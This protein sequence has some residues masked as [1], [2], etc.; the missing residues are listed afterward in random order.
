MSVEISIINPINVKIWDEAVLSSENY[1]F[2]HSVAWSKVL[3]N[4]YGYKPYYFVSGNE[5]KFSTLIPLMQIDSILTGRR[6]I[7][8]PFSDFCEPIINGTGNIEEIFNSIKAFAKK[9]GWKYIQFRGGQKLFRNCISSSCFYHHYLH[10]TT[11]EEKLTSGFSK[12]TNRNIRKAIREGL[13]TKISYSYDAV[14]EFYNL[15][16]YTRKKHGLPSQP[17]YFFNELFDQIISH[18][19]GLVM[20]AMKENEILAGAVFLHLGRKAVFKYGASKQKFLHLR[21]NNLIMCDAIKWYAKNGYRMLSFGRTSFDNQ[22]LRRFKC[23]WGTEEQLINYYRYNSAKDKFEIDQ[24]LSFYWLN[25]VLKKL[26]LPILKAI[27]F[28]L[29]RHIG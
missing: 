23:G 3:N 9:C 1:S 10:L 12:V 18:K 5:K 19:K 26:P 16:C 8:L 11:D 4:A 14:K 27:G 15:N 28:V 20:L 7:S 22:G 25:K 24:N 17:L 2:F 21:P 29:Y 6:G 13:E